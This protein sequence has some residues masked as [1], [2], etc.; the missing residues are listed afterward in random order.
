[1]FSAFGDISIG[2]NLDPRDDARGVVAR[3]VELVNQHPVDSVSN[4][5]F[6]GHWLEVDV[7]CTFFNRRSYQLIDHL[8][9][10]VFAGL[11]LGLQ[12]MIFNLLIVG[13]AGILA[14]EQSVDQIELLTDG[15]AGG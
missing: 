3:K 5:E 8:N 15:R 10:A 14:L 9:Y 7:G 1:V 6:V 13:D 11:S 4:A 12:S 2:E